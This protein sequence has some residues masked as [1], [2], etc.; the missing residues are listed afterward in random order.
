MEI[1]FLHKLVCSNF[2]NWF[3]PITPSPATTPREEVK[4][5]RQLLFLISKSF[6]ISYE[7]LKR[8]VFFFGH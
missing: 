7:F 1:P 6:Y 5:V 8:E 4:K 3:Y 2:E